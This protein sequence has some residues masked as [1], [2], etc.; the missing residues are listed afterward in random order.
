MDEQLEEQFRARLHHRLWCRLRDQ[1]G[2]KSSDQ[3]DKHLVYHH[4][5]QILLQFWDHLDKELKK[6]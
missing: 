5:N 4:G 3:L 1:L 2:Y 6:E